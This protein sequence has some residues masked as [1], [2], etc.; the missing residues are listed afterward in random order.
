MWARSCRIQ[1]QSATSARNGLVQ[2]QLPIVD[3]RQIVQGLQIVRS[4]VERFMPHAQRI[5]ITAHPLID[6]TQIAAED[7]C[8]GS[9]T[10]RALNRLDG[11]LV[12]LQAKKH[13]ALVMQRE[14][15]IWRS[16]QNVV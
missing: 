8:L 11:R 13:N 4:P 14:R 1:R 5:V 15:L 16:R 2:L 9:Q 12:S 6:R 10:D 3:D 7:R